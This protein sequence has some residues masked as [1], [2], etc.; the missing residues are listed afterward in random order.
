[1]LSTEYTDIMLTGNV[2]D[3]SEAGTFLPGEAFNL[4]D[5]LT[6]EIEFE[7]EDV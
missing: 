5:S 3:L 4:M 1:M 2:M 6:D 7:D